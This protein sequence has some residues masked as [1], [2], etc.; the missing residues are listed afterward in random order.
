MPTSQE[1]KTNGESKRGSS[2]QDRLKQFGGAA[3]DAQVKP[4]FTVNKRISEAGKPNEPL[5]AKRASVPASSKTPVLGDTKT[6]TSEVETLLSRNQLSPAA[7]E[8]QRNERSLF[9]KTGNTGQFQNGAAMKSSSQ[10]NGSSQQEDKETKVLPPKETN[11]TSPDNNHKKTTNGNTIIATIPIE[12]IPVSPGKTVTASIE[13]ETPA[14]SG[15]LLKK[16]ESEDDS[17]DDLIF[18]SPPDQ[19]QPS[20]M[21]RL[22]ELALESD[23]EDEEETHAPHETGRSDPQFPTMTQLGKVE[24]NDTVGPLPRPPSSSPSEPNAPTLDTSANFLDD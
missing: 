9:S 10:A 6:S 8:K 16:R 17:D 13:K 19:V 1:E 2:I 22:S 23:E 20:G 7:A 14:V 18:S 21:K 4:N 11:A 12:E 5:S 3:K 24:Y 15:Q